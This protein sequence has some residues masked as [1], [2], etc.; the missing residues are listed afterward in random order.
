MIAIDAWSFSLEVH[1]AS[2]PDGRLVDV[3]CKALVDRVVLERFVD[4]QLIIYFL[5]QLVD[6]YMQT[7]NLFVLVFAVL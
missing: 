6:D 1:L 7:L 5:L 3:V 4:E 2:D